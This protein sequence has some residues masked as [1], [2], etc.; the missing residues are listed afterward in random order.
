[1]SKELQKERRDN[2]L[3]IRCGKKGH[4]QYTCAAPKPVISSTS[5]KRKSPT[6]SVDE[7][8]E[9]RPGKKKSREDRIMALERVI[10]SMKKVGSKKGRILKLKMKKIW[11][12]L[13]G[14]PKIACPRVMVK[15][16]L[17]LGERAG[18]RLTDVV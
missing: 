13:E 4:G 6:P 1:M 14:E 15:G 12:I 18:R 5:R 11:R 3:C 8:E 9:E 7:E 2:K 10:A 16:P 17:S